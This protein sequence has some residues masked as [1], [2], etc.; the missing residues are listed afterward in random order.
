ME[1]GTEL[2]EAYGKIR[3]FHKLTIDYLFKFI[4]IGSCPHMA[5][6]VTRHC[7]SMQSTDCRRDG[8]GQVVL[9][10]PVYP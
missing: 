10:V 3:S 1:E 9:A 5:T 4:V 6:A 8:D 7:T 2:V